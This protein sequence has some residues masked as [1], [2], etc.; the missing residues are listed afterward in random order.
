MVILQHRTIL[1]MQERCDIETLVPI[2]QQQH[3]H[4]IEAALN[5]P[6][7][8]MDVSN[9]LKTIL[10]ETKGVAFTLFLGSPKWFQNR[11]SMMINLL[12]G[13]LPKDWIIQIFY[14]PKNKMSNEAVHH[15]GIQK[16]V[17]KGNV[18]LIPIPEGYSKLKK[19]ELM[20]LPWVWKQL[21]AERVLTFGGTNVLCSNSPL[22]LDVDFGNFDFIGSPSREFNG[23][24]GDGGLSL[25]NRT[26]VLSILASQ[27]KS[28]LKDESI[29]LKSMLNTQNRVATPEQ[30]LSFAINDGTQNF[31]VDWNP[32]NL[33]KYARGSLPL[34]AQGTLGGLSDPQRTKAL[35]YCP[36][37]KMF[38]PVL[39][40]GACFGASPRPLECFK[41][42][43]EYGGLRCDKDAALTEGLEYSVNTKKDP[44]LKGVLMMRIVSTE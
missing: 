1:L 29:I 36:E 42:L 32:E 18:I 30:T 35:D 23:M 44:S 10:P 25:R 6:I 27:Q 19:R 40:S 9:S 4:H 34:G 26:S 17:Q 16:Q 12:H 37:L 11:Y 21:R 24:G 31:E 33:R 41:F 43:C 3:H 2:R 22:D 8:A 5:A 28:E 38:F 15:P 20:T 13:A 7:V 14:L 39:H